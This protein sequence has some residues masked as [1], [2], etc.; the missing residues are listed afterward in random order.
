M[1]IWDCSSVKPCLDNPENCT[2]RDIVLCAKTLYYHFK[3]VGYI[4]NCLEQRSFPEPY[5]GS[6]MTATNVFYALE[7]NFDRPFNEIN[8]Q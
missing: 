6:L 4:R 2:D 3:N 5:L 7:E 8:F 1:N